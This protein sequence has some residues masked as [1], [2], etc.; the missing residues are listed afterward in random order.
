M[1]LFLPS[2]LNFKIAQS[3]KEWKKTI[4]SCKSLFDSVPII[5]AKAENIEMTYEFFD[6]ISESPYH[7]ILNEYFIFVFEKDIV[8]KDNF[9]DF[10][11]EFK[12]EHVLNKNSDDAT[13]AVISNE[14]YFETIEKI[15][16]L[17]VKQRIQGIE[18]QSIE[19][20]FRHGIP[21]TPETLKQMIQTKVNKIKM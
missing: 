8:W 7:V 10:A 9:F 3:E 16:S 2:I 15:K 18:K 11:G 17:A 21:I 20:L 1:D 4:E 19:E 12:T 14:R 13:I 5:I 6:N